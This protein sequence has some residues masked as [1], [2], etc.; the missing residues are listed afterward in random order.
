MFFI[1]FFILF[2]LFYFISIFLLPIP[3][4]YNVSFYQWFFSSLQYFNFLKLFFLLLNFVISLFLSWF[5][6]FF[7]FLIF[8]FIIKNIN[9]NN[10]YYFKRKV[11]SS[12]SQLIVHF[13]RIEIKVNNINYIPLKEKVIIYSNH[14]SFFD[15]FILSSVF[16]IN[17]TFTPKSELYNGFLGYLRRFCFN[18]LD[19]IEI[20]RD[21]KRQTV[22]NI[23]KTIE[24]MNKNLL[25]V[26]VFHEGGRKNKESDK[27]VASLEGAF[28]IAL[29]SKSSILPVSI[30]GSSMLIG[31]CWF[32]KQKVELFIH[33][34]IPF[35]DFKELKT[36]EINDKI[37]N[38]INSVL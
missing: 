20:V 14:K 26:V 2:F 22:L 23:N 36:Q 34:Y 27:I 7:I 17:I 25:S 8:L 4:F 10:N 16:P 37:N 28:K 1:I 5:S 30:K 13:F 18:T 38:I 19:C 21:N 29:K 31:K 24:K 35:K 6:I 32:K 12:F 9:I 11:L 33:P 3:Y 15:A